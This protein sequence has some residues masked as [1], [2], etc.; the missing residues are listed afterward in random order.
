[1]TIDIILA[2]TI[3][4]MVD[5]LYRSMKRS[6]YRYVNIELF[7]GLFFAIGF[8]F[9]RAAYVARANAA[10]EELTWDDMI[11]HIANYPRQFSFVILFALFVMAVLLGISNISLIRHEGFRPKNMLGIVLSG[12]YICGT[13]AIYALDKYIN[14]NPYIIVFMLFVLCYF[15][16]VLIATAVLG[17]IAAKQKPAYDKDYIIIPGCAISKQG[18]LLPLLKGR[19]NR[20]IKYAWDQEIASGKPVHYVPS[21]G[22]GPNEVISEGSAME[23]YLLSHGAEPNEVF[24]EK[25]SVNTYQNFKYS[26]KIIDSLN[27]NAKVAFATT[28]YH[29]LRCGMLAYRLGMN[30]EGIS[31]ST[32]WYFWPNGFVR[33][34]IAILAMNKKIHLAVIAVFAIICAIMS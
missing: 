20:A 8:L 27:P 31:S 9:V 21:G 24:P 18:G 17:F 19:T 7:A 5:R 33:E 1:M 4:L 22:Q 3:A 15:E 11:M 25:E 28:N 6:L 26:K 32:K 14:I 23:L 30:A 12:M 10:G 16:C 13:L 2:F 29:M 34:F